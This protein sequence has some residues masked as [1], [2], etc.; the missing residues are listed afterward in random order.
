[1]GRSGRR[2]NTVPILR[3]YALE[4]ELTPQSPLADSLRE[5]L[6]QFGAQIAMLEEGWFEPPRAGGMHLSTLVQQLLSVIG[7]YGTLDARTAYFLLCER[8]PFRSVS[9]ADFLTLIQSLGTQRVLTQDSDGALMHSELGERIVNHYSFYAAFSSPEEY[10]LMWS[11]KPL[12]SLP[13]TYP[14][15]VGDYLLFGGKRWKVERVSAD[16]KTIDVCPARGGRAPYFGGDAGVVHTLVRQKMKVILADTE[17]FRFF[18]TKAK[19]LLEG[20]RAT[21]RA[22]GLAYEQRLCAGAD[23]HLFLWQGDEIQTTFALLLK[24]Q[25][26]T[27]HNQGLVVLVENCD[28]GKL[29]ET[30]RSLAESSE[31]TPQE[32]L[33]GAENL[34]TEK[35]DM[36]VPSPLRERNYA[37]LR[38]DLAGTYAL[39]RSGAQ[40]GQDPRRGDV[41]I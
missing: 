18:D 39:I 10:R 24:S 8:G 21:F 41:Y 9:K 5:S 37:S 26:I 33:R 35:W 7:Q 2:K 29:D 38:L 34:V 3:G 25:G 28:K 19:E 36:F 23:L 22:A 27:A 32:L 15:S 30:L 1:M 6:V 14:V 12:G 11:G 31:L 4:P 17:P 13:I 40:F 16:E 20:A